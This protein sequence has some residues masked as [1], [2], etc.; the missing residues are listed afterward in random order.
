MTP[1]SNGRRAAAV[2]GGLAALSAMVLA[3][4]ICGVC[5]A[6]AAAPDAKFQPNLDATVRYLQEVQN[7]DGG[8]A[9][10]RG[11]K[12]IPE[13]SAWVALALAAAGINPRDQTTAAQHYAGGHS[14]YSY[15][16]EHV[17]GLALTTD[18][19][20]VL[21]VVDAAGT[22]P[23]EFGGVNLV[24][25]ILNAQLTQPGPNEGAFA[26]KVGSSEPGMNDTIFAIL[27]LSPIKEVKVEHAVH[28][29]A[30][31]VQAEQDCDH[32]WPATAPRIIAPCPVGG[33][34]LAGEP[35][36]EVDMTG[37]AIEALNAAGMHDT[38]AQSQAFRFLHETQEPLDG[39]FPEFA[40]EGESN[41]A[42]SAW[43]TQGIWSAGQ[44][45]ETWLTQTGLEPLGYMASM[46]QPDGHIRYRAHEELNGVWMTAYV[47][48]AF[49]GDPLPI[50]EVPFEELPPEPPSPA[51]SGHGGVSPQPG[52]GVIA[53]GGGK[54]APLF[55]RPQP[56][57][58]GHTPGGVRLLRSSSEHI[59]R[60]GRNPGRPRKTAVPTAG[61]LPRPSGDHKG[62]D[63]ELAATAPGSK[64]AGVSSGTGGTGQGGQAAG[65]EVKGVLIGAPA[66]ADMRDA[67]EP[68]APGLHSAQAG[69]NQSPWLAIAIG[70]AIALLVI[71]GSQLE[72]R[73][74]QA[75]L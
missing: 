58:K 40:G 12:S 5:P 8:F 69:G 52:S 1:R 51:E 21:L 13:F 73:R 49:A 39:G 16:A 27:A 42:S 4:S 67:L 65:Q 24:E 9:G 44:N 14:V 35:R 31:W 59:A 17:D 22:S 33:G 46:Q 34:E 70:G 29:A 11:G 75:I 74:P 48:P 7:E 3:L 36:S 57:S 62:L 72:R 54:R 50:P 25:D 10:N 53:G 30:E 45:P 23:Y 37:A 19:E 2:R 63:L 68:G 47:T 41:V 66:I 15:L 26:H 64:K 6:L 20:R 38:D 60:H 43:A 55:S 61:Q 28:R 18:F 32:G 71:A 56:D